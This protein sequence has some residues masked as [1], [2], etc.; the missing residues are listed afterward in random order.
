[1]QPANTEA[2]PAREAEAPAGASSK[3]PPRHKRPVVD[4]PRHKET[5]S[6][7]PAPL[8]STAP[9]AGK[10]APGQCSKEVFAAVYNGAAPSKDEIRAAI[11]N[12]NACHKAGAISDAEL[13]ETQAALVSRF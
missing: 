6:S 12:L 5:R 13:D 4:A 2:R 11:R 10:P 9:P 8:A 1:L 7:T 3:K